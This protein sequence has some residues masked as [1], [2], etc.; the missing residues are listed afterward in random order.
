MYNLIFMCTRTL[1]WVSVGGGTNNKLDAILVVKNKTQK[2]DLCKD[3]P[4]CFLDTFEYISKIKIG[5]PIDYDYL[6]SEFKTFSE[7]EVR[8]E[9]MPPTVETPPKGSLSKSMKVNP[10]RISI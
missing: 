10:R 7:K 9:I 1:P 4:K 8:T 5:D 2:S 3:L 6:A